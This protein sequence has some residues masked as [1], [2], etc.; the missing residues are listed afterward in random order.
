ML[1]F[2]LLFSVNVYLFILFV[3]SNDQLKL[4]QLC[5]VILDNNNVAL[6]AWS[7]CSISSLEDFLSIKVFRENL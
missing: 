4:T 2:Y 6:I 5:T 7:V 1:Q 3:V